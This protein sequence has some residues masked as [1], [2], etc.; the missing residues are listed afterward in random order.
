M[1]LFRRPKDQ[2]AAPLEQ[3]VTRE[4]G[5]RVGDEDFMPAP[6][7]PDEGERGG[8]SNYSYWGST[9][10]SFLKDQVAVGFLLV[11]VL[12]LL[13]TFIQPLLP[14]QFEAN[15]IIDH[16]LTKRQMSNVAPAWTNVVAEA[17][18]GLFG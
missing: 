9:L 11:L 16:P 13:F 10:R 7:D 8:Y 14:Q 15:V 2:I 5:R 6:Y 17:P 18:V 12:L 4:I 3:A 1:R